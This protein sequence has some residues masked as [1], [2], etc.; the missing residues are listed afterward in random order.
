[1][2]FVSAP[3]PHFVHLTIVASTSVPVITG[4]VNVQFGTVSLKIFQGIALFMIFIVTL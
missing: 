1:M 3:Q 4:T 2:E